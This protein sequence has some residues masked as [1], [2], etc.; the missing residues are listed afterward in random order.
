MT[1]VAGTMTAMKATV[2]AP[3]APADDRVATA[4]S[5]ATPVEDVAALAI[6]FSAEF[7]EMPGL[8]L[9]LRQAA[10]LFSVDVEVALAV[11]DA[12]RRAAILRLSDDGRYSLLSDR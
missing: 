11:L 7:R 2:S 8:R 1:N 12:L 5:A 10:R 6:R 4:R 9:T 3:A